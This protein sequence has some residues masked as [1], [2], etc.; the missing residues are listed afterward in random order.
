MID[1]L[2]KGNRNRPTDD[3]NIEII[4]QRLVNNYDQ[5]T[6]ESLNTLNKVEEMRILKENYQL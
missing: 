6:Q 2:K 5:Y 1:G 3:S 4:Q